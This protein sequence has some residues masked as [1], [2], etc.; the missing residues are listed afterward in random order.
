MSKDAKRTDLQ[1]AGFHS[2]RPCR[3]G[4]WAGDIAA[5][6]WSGAGSHLPLFAL[7]VCDFPPFQRGSHVFTDVV[8]CLP[9]RLS[10]RSAFKSR[11]SLIRR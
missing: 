1:I 5:S 7:R 4:D 2:K 8:R 9:H 6:L 10:L 11:F 3:P